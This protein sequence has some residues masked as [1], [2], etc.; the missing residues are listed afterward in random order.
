MDDQPA[1]D[2]QPNDTTAA[3]PEPDTAPQAPV[4]PWPTPPHGG[5]GAQHPWAGGSWPPPPPPHTTA[6]AGIP[7]VPPPGMPPGAGHPLYGAVP[8]HGAPPYAAW[9]WSATPP[10]RPAPVGRVVLALVVA[11]GVLVAAVLGGVV[12]HQIWR[13][14]TSNPFGGASG[15]GAGQTAPGGSGPQDA[16]SI[17]SHVDP[18]LV[19]VNSVIETQGLQGA[20]TGM[21]LTPDGEVLTNNHVVEGASRISVTDVGNGRTYSASVVGYDRAHDIAV[22]QLSGASGLQTVSLGDSSKVNVGQG[23]VAV[24]NA[25]GTGGTPSFAGGT[26]TGTD[27]TITA[28]DQVDGSSEQLSGLIQTNAAI[29]SGDSGG[30]LVNTAGQVIGMDTA[31]SGG[32]SF[33]TSG[34]Q[35]YAIPINT[36][37]GIVRQIRGGVSTGTVHV[38]PTAFL[39]VEVRASGGSGNGF[40]GGPAAPVAGAEIVGVV[41]DGPAASAGLVVGEV[42]TAVNG[43]SVGSA[44]ALTA[45]MLGQKPGTTVPVAYTDT[46]GQQHTVDVRLASGP[47]Q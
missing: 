39:G 3:A 27:Q 43:H 18:G 19:D 42:I 14:S 23:V 38:G 31:A 17:A 9:G 32:Y 33:Q 11:V 35:G 4:P 15:P 30:P 28:S 21:V 7:A 2:E 24:G 6:G 37:L 22:L 16:S 1:H 41:S 10:P 44:E 8:P 12:G 5:P 46:L 26:V 29:V 45:V 13:S 47:P 40:G 25:N 34:S 20:G 36:A